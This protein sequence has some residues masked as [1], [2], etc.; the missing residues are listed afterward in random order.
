MERAQKVIMVEQA[1][2]APKRAKAKKSENSFL[3]DQKEALRIAP[4]S[5]V[6]D[7]SYPRSTAE[8][9]LKS[10]KAAAYQVNVG[11]RRAWPSDEYYAIWRQ[12]P[13]NPDVYQLLIG[14]RSYLKEEWAGVVNRAG[15][16]KASLQAKAKGGEDGADE[17]ADSPWT[18]EV[19]E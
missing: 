3:A 5:L 17:A 10:V 18:E 11:E 9:S 8:Q 16:R 12:S 1:P 14:K 2:P 4:D 19:D 15:S 7:N 6:V 13:D